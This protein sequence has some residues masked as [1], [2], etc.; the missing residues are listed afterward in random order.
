MRKVATAFGCVFVLALIVTA[1]AQERI[2]PN[3][4]A[5]YI[6]KQATVCG[7]VASATYAA[8]SGGRPTFLNLDRPY[9]NQIFTALIWSENRDKFP[10]PTEK[11]YRGK[12]ICV[13]GTVLSY[14][15]EPQIVVNSPLQ[16][17]TE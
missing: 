14:R 5:K 15:G 10:T 1:L 17:V 3:E 16:I 7:Q 12:R 13:T 9:P 11:A 2:T 4:A 8:R 6:G